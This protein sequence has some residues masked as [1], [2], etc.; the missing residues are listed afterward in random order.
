[1]CPQH[2][3]PSPQSS[4]EMQTLCTDPDLRTPGHPLWASG[5]ALWGSRLPASLQSPDGPSSLRLCPCSWL[6]SSCPLGPLLPPCSVSS[7]PSHPRVLVSA[8]LL[9]HSIHSFLT[10]LF[11]FMV[12]AHSGSVHGTQMA[13]L[14][15]RAGLC[16]EHQH[17]CPPAHQHLS[18]TPHTGPHEVQNCTGSVREVKPPMEALAGPAQGFP[19]A[20][21]WHAPP[22]PTRPV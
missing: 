17:S 13:S 9:T 14:P 2:W 5:A 19:G 20:L 3:H 10:I 18:Q 16:P 12:S 21:S 11:H 7:L 1:M 6:S 4:L 15:L 22:K 8:L